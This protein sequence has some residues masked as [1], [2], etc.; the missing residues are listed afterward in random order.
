MR[1]E[2]L[3]AVLLVADPPLSDGVCDD[4]GYLPRL[5]EAAAEAKLGIYALVWFGFDGD[6]KWKD[7]M[8]RLVKLIQTNPKVR[9]PPSVSKPNSQVVLV[10]QA[11]YVIRT[12]AVGSEPLFDHVLSADDLAAQ[13]ISLRST[14]KPY[15]IETSEQ[16]AKSQRC[17]Y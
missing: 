1:C 7:R 17:I 11:P 8:A 4:P 3:P 9:P 10:S 12:I 15:G 13:V 16:L 5:V 6:S 14:L 2:R